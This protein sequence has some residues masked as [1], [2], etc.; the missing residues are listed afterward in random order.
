MSL[1]DIEKLKRNNKELQEIINNSWDGI[2]IIDK[3]TKLI[4]VNNAFMPI[5]GFNKDELINTKLINYMKSEYINHFLELL[6]I[7]TSENKKYKAEIDLVCIRKDKEK[8]YLKITI[9]TMLNKSLFVINTKDITSQVS[10]DEILDDYVASMHIDLHGY[11]TKVS[12]AFL[13]LFE[14]KKD[15]IINTPYKKL[16]DE[17]TNKIIFENIDKTLEA[18]QEFSGKIKAVKNN[19]YLFFINIK[20]KP[21]Y[22]KYGDVIGYTSLIFD[23]SNQLDLKEE[24]TILEEE[25]DNAKKEIVEKNNLLKNQS[26][27]LIITETLQKLSHEWRQ[28]LNLISVQAQKLE[29]DYSMGITPSEED[30]VKSLDKI[31]NEAD[32][33]SKTIESFQHFIKNNSKESNTSIKKIID[34][35]IRRVDLNNNINVNINI[36]EEFVFTTLEEELIEVLTNILINSNEQYQRTNKKDA[37]I[38][39]YQYHNEDK[40]VFEI[41]DNLGGISEDIL[42]KVFEPYFSTKKKKHGVGLGLY[43][44]KLIIN[45]QLQGVI[46]MTNKDEGILVKISIPTN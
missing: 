37:Q 42:H 35:V 14:Y 11:I 1:E 46:T 26:K 39:I 25:I 16:F 40:I 19:N 13:K 21:M 7:E 8:V 4:Y 12:N 38:D 31:K 17:N 27:M 9:S 45:L 24:S 30:A 3:S 10:D 18:Q 2:G 32:K 36:D 15:D 5:L 23:I 28:P 43:I 22:N 44:S 41:K 34:A 29:L 20:I 33:L 6:N